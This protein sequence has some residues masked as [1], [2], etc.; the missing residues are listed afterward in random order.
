M[1]R[2]IPSFKRK[3]LQTVTKWEGKKWFQFISILQFLDSEISGIDFNTLG[4]YCPNFLEDQLS[5]RY[6]QFCLGRKL[7]LGCSAQNSCFWEKILSGPAST[8]VSL[9]EGGDLKLTVSFLQSL[10]G[11][12]SFCSRDSF[13]LQ[14]RICSN[15]FFFFFPLFLLPTLTSFINLYDFLAESASNTSCLM[16]KVLFQYG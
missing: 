12:Q 10:D 16:R 1:P 15:S 2:L 8:A 14:I 13:S 7:S 3:Q 9:V 11:L 6:T 5:R 4:L